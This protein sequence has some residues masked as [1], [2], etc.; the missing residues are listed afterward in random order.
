[1]EIKIR[2]IED[3]DRDE[4]I[5]VEKGAMPHNRYINDVW[6]LFLKE[7][8]GDL[9]G[10]FVDG[11][12][13]GMGK[14]TVLYNGYGWLETLR[15]HPD[16]QNK[17]IG[18]KIYDAY[19]KY[20]KDLKLKSVGMYTEMYNK[21]S[22]HLAEKN[23]LTV[24]A[25]YTEILKPIYESEENFNDFKQVTEKEG[26]NLISKYYNEMDDYI[27]I[28]RTFYPV[29]KGLGEVLAKN[30]WVYKNENDDILIAGFRFQPEKAFHVP[31]IR[32]NI[33]HVLKFANYLG[34]KAG[35]KNLSILKPVNSK[36]I[37]L[38]TDN[39]FKIDDDYMTLWIDL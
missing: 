15:V 32:G 18:Q 12:L 25:E 37:N 22:K 26:E 30:G 9:I 21:I 8:K 17:G 39:G 19:I 20:M 5:Y 23:G 7:T 10:V 24:R 33:E 28:N 29:K 1:M 2:A 6:N 31:F 16:Y 3:K 13:Q 36:E 34:F 35:S 11:K 27:V 38:F 4:C 14:L